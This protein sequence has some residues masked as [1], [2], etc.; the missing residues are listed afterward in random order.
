MTVFEY[1]NNRVTSALP[2]NSL[3]LSVMDTAIGKGLTIKISGNNFL[4]F[5]EMSVYPCKRKYQVSCLKVC[6]PKVCILE[7]KFVH[8]DIRK[9]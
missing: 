9:G 5:G 4:F 1:N 8:K 6:T 2:K 7:R 3:E